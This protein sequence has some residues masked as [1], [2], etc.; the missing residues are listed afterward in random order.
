MK[1]LNARC[2]FSDATVSEWMDDVQ[3][4]AVDEEVSI[5]IVAVVLQITYMYVSHTE[6]EM[7]S[8]K[9]IAQAWHLSVCVC[10]H[11]V[12]NVKVRKRSIIMYDIVK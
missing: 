9:Y 11:N 7:Q 6:Y 12:R 8:C 3:H 5:Q 4:S 1:G 10:K 2:G